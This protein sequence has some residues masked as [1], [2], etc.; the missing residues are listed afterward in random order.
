MEVKKID[1][2][3]RSVKSRTG[4]VGCLTGQSVAG[5]VCVGEAAH[6]V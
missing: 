1:G 5:Q 4:S 2:I 3:H 6:S